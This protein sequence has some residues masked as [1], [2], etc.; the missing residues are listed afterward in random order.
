MKRQVIEKLKKI[1][2]HLFI[3]SFEKTLDV[4]DKSIRRFGFIGIINENN[5]EEDIIQ[6]EY[7]FESAP[8]TT[9]PKKFLNNVN[10]VKIPPELILQEKGNK[11]K[12]SIIGTESVI[13]NYR[14][15]PVGD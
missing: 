8:N 7:F 11:L 1:D 12:S 13:F 14:L 2:T 9:Y 5:S 10:R 4:L 15:V 6:I 3:E